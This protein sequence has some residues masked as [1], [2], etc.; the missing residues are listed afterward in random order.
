MLRPLRFLLATVCLL[1][2]FSVSAGGSG[3]VELLFADIRLEVPGN[4]STLAVQ[5]KELFLALR[6]GPESGQDYVIFTDHPAVPTQGCP[7]DEFFSR[8]MRQGVSFENEQCDTGLV[9][10]F[11]S[12]FVEQADSGIWIGEHLKAYYFL[13]ETKSMVYLIG[14]SGE[15]IKLD[16][17]FLSADE[18]EQ[19]VSGA[20]PL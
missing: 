14:A 12:A 7:P 20:R 17:D 16:T 2:S 18:L 8:A 1:A 3:T 5:E 13:Q 11:R 9:E 4:P 10:D 19:L 6:Y 15:Y